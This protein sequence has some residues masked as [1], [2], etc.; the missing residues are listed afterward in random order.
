MRTI[1]HNGQPIVTSG[2]FDPTT[3]QYDQLDR[4]DSEVSYLTPLLR[5]SFDLQRQSW[6]WMWWVRYLAIQRT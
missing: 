6:I 1:R 3:S 4:D 5:S 2:D